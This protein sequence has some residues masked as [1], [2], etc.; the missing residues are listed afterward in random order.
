MRDTGCGM[1]G[2]KAPIAGSASA[3][4]VKPGW[5]HGHGIGLPL[6]ETL[7]RDMGAE[8]Q[9]DSEAQKGTAATILFSGFTQRFR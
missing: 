1:N 7:V 9:I 8:I 6:V 2:S 5:A 4:D 3:A